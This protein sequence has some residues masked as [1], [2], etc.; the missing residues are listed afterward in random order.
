MTSYWVMRRSVCLIVVSGGTVLTGAVIRW[1][2]GAGGRIIQVTIFEAAMPPQIGAAI[3]AMDHKLDPS[4]VA[5][6]VGLG[7]P[8]SF[9]TLVAWSKILAVL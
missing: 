8:L 4:L 6:M 3:M 9:L 2:M 1:L 5:L 7:I